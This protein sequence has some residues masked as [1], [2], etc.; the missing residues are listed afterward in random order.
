M[1]I[2]IIID[3]YNLIRHSKDLSTLDLQD[4]QLGREALIGMLA[5]YKK[6][7]AHRITVVF[8]GT[9]A[10]DLA[11]QR[12]RQ[13]GISIIFS[14]HGESADAVIKK[15][16]AGEKQKALVVSS[17]QDIVRSAE[18]S[19]AATI[20]AND[21]ENKLILATQLNG[22]GS[23]RDDYD[24]WTPTTKKKGPSR[25]LSNRQRKNQAKVRK[26]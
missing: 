4:I 3:G 6:I 11:Q 12:D 21:F 24:G 1:S 9:R 23:D 2:H 16:A 13:K 26:L 8:D 17:D 19:G 7:K 22:A 5:A 25:R 15:M 10:P 14:H 20:N 18:S